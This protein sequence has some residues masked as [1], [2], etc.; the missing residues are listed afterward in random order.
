M[1]L[2]SAVTGPIRFR[3]LSVFLVATMFAQVHGQQP[4]RSSAQSDKI[5]AKI[6]KIGIR[7]DVTVKLYSGK[8]YY[9][10]INRIDDQQFE[11]SEVDLK[12]NLVIR[13]DEVRRVERGY[14]EKGPLGNRV[15]KKWRR[16]GTIIGAAAIAIPLI[17]VAASIED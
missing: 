3:L 1:P 12:T 4:Q 2:N 5:F 7:A 16:I 8:T 15:S 17:I 10:F 13:Y 14:G 9:G 6:T 11:M